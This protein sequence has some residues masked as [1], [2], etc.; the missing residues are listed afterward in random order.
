MNPAV[1]AI[2][3]G[4]PLPAPFLIGILVDDMVVDALPQGNKELWTWS[5]FC[6]DMPLCELNQMEKEDPFTI[7]TQYL[8]FIGYRL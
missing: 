2:G 5:N 3:A 6:H 1:S 7:D 8:V 4:T